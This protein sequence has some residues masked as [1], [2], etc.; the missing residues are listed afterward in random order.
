MRAEC[1]IVVLRTALPAVNQSRRQ[2]VL[3]S[4]RPTQSIPLAASQTA[5]VFVGRIELIA[6][7]TKRPVVQ[8]AA[9]IAASKRMF[10][11]APSKGK[12][13]RTASPDSGRGSALRWDCSEGIADAEQRRELL[14]NSACC[15]V[16]SRNNLL[17]GERRQIVSKFRTQKHVR[18][19]AALD[20]SPNA[21][22][23][24]PYVV[25]RQ[26]R[27]LGNRLRKRSGTSDHIFLC[28]RTSCQKGAP[29]AF[30]RLEVEQQSMVNASELPCMSVLTP[31][32]CRNGW[33]S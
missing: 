32:A 21:E 9:A 2:F 5:R 4:S 12:W 1:P 20:A 27:D 25:R 11:E 13:R 24:L 30:A 33:P 6:T 26:A 16:R 15:V 28:T 18:E 8:A 22:Y 17:P 31:P 3:Q 29:T 14:K 10:V 19:D 23:D 7:E